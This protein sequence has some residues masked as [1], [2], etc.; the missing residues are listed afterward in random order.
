MAGGRV[1]GDFAT[2][3][4][5]RV[6]A[7]AVVAGRSLLDCAIDAAVGAG[8]AGVA[9]VGGPE[10]RAACA[11]RVD[12]IIDES[13]LGSENLH[14]ALWAWPHAPTLLL[15]SD[16]PFVQAEDVRRFIAAVPPRTLAMPLAREEVY[17]RRF[18]NAPARVTP[19]LG[20]RVANGCRF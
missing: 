8:A 2:L 20:E 5:T 18:P 10:V 15:S 11:S 6:K 17:R 1:D 4:G 9:V 19:R 16:L 13:C 7:L 12:C 3:I 14:R